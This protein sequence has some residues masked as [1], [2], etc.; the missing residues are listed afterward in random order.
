MILEMVRE[1]IQCRDELQQVIEAA[2]RESKYLVLFEGGPS[3][4]NRLEEVF[5]RDAVLV[6]LDNEISGHVSDILKGELKRL[7]H[8]QASLSVILV[9]HSESGVEEVNT[10]A[11]HTRG[12]KR[13]VV[14]ATQVERQLQQAKSQFAG[15]VETLFSEM[16]NLGKS[17]GEK[18]QVQALFYH[19]A[20]GL[21][22][23]YDREQ[24]EFL[25]LIGS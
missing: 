18:L 24:K 6:P 20:A 22:L 2:A 14:G 3:L 13:W 8:M 15:R 9:G 23:G 5:D 21:F 16:S 12:Y 17:E 1:G 10:E 7:N 19:A 11:S 4:R 25:P